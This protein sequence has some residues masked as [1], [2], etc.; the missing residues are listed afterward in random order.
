MNKVQLI[1]AGIGF[2]AGAAFKILELL[3]GASAKDIAKDPREWL[4]T[5][6]FAALA[7]GASYVLARWQPADFAQT[8][9]PEPKTLTSTRTIRR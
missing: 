4:A 6:I 1:S 9:P 3:A 8:P 5:A 2:A 7:A